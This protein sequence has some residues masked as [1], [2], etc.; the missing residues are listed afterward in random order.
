[1]PGFLDTSDGVKTS[2]TLPLSW[3][4]TS[5]YFMFWISTHHKIIILCFTFMFY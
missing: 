5:N 1:M 3:N 2:L 4:N